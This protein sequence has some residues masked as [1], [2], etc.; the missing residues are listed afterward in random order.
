MAEEPAASAAMVPSTDDVDMP[1]EGPKLSFHQEP[2]EVEA[3]AS[4]GRSEDAA[5]ASL[6]LQSRQAMIATPTM[7][8]VVTSGAA[9]SAQQ[10]KPLQVKQEEAKVGIELHPW[11]EEDPLPS[12]HSNDPFR[13]IAATAGLPKT[14]LQQIER[15]KPRSASARM[16]QQ[17][18]AKPDR[19]EWLATAPRMMKKKGPRAGGKPGERGPKKRNFHNIGISFSSSRTLS[20]ARND[21]II[22]TELA[23][24]TREDLYTKLFRSS[25]SRFNH[26]IAVPPHVKQ[27]ASNDVESVVYVGNKGAHSS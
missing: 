25:R 10:A 9:R 2:V 11:G 14:K 27:R 26:R 12:F 7:K 8:V 13:N 17:S 4:R 20:T 22:V 6:E 15:R 16:P 21:D 1:D 18:F 5:A 3:T 19:R 24:G 23:A